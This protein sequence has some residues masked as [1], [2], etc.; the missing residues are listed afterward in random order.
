[1]CL[2]SESSI[3]QLE[4]VWFNFLYLRKM[5]SREADYL[6]AVTLLFCLDLKENQ[7]ST[8]LTSKLPPTHHDLPFLSYVEQR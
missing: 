6:I 5:R 2:E 8:F 4:I 7:I 3:A 1:M